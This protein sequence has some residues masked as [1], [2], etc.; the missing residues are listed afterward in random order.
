MHHRSLGEAYEIAAEQFRKVSRLST[1][2]RE[3]LW[4]LAHGRFGSFELR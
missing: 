2:Y 4:L 1:G 3:K